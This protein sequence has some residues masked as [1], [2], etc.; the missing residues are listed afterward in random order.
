[1]G[2]T[3]FSVTL[4]LHDDNVIDVAIINWLGAHPTRVE[5]APRGRAYRY[6]MNN[7]IKLALYS[8]IM[9][10]QG[11]P[12]DIQKYLFSQLNWAPSSVISNPGFST[13]SSASSLESPLAIATGP[14]AVGLTAKGSN[15]VAAEIA[16]G[17]ASVS[18]DPVSAI[19]G[20][21]ENLGEPVP[22]K[23]ARFVY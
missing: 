6:G 13:K 20:E 5:K 3:K 18:A 21:P 9:A 15:E 11:Q 19:P 22:R 1:M 12:V 7:E 23:R 16:D 8:Y 17:G 10:L 14:L 4:Q 2:P